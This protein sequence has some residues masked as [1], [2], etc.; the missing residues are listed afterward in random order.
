MRRS[1]KVVSFRADEDLLRQIDEARLPLGI[2]RGDWTR[3]IVQSHLLQ[4]DQQLLHDE[5]AELREQVMQ[6][7]DAT[8]VHQRTLVKATYL[9]LT[10]SDLPPDEAKE[11]VR[12]T[13]G[14]GE[15]RSL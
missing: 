10:N 14:A 15:G 2:S 8:A 6:L 9:Q 13:L 11:L 5:I 7:A 4:T 12:R 3:A 1:T